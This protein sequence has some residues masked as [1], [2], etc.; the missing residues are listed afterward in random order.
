MHFDACSFYAETN[1]RHA[2]AVHRREVTT[3]RR[4]RDTNQRRGNAQ[5]N[6]DGQHA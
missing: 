6:K 1:D 5:Q 4:P 2:P 3:Q